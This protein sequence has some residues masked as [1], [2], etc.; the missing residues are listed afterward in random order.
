MDELPNVLFPFLDGEKSESPDWWFPISIKQYEERVS[1]MQWLIQH[2]A[3]RWL[4]YITMYDYI[5]IKILK[6]WNERE[7]IPET[8]KTYLS[9]LF[10]GSRSSR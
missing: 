4:S 9:F 2:K 10:S 1:R 7:P 6:F 8:K 3:G 5:D